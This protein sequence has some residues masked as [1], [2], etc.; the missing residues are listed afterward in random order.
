MNNLAKKCLLSILSFAAA[1]IVADVI[2]GIGL[3]VSSI[4]SE[5]KRFRS[6]V[7]PMETRTVVF[8]GNIDD[9]YEEPARPLDDTRFYR[10]QPRYFRTDPNGYIRGAAATNMGGGRIYRIT[11]CGDSVT[12]CFEV[13]EDVRF[14]SLVGKHMRESGLASVDTRSMGVRGYTSQDALNL[15]IN[16]PALRRNDMLVFMFNG[17]DIGYLI[18]KHS[19]LTEVPLD[20]RY[21]LSHLR[22]LSANCLDELVTAVCYNSNLAFLM[23]QSGDRI[24][25]MRRTYYTLQDE[26]SLL[27]Q[28]HE[29]LRLLIFTCRALNIQPVFM[30]QPSALPGGTARRFNEA[31]VEAGL[32]NGVWVVDAASAFPKES[33]Q[34]FFPDGIHL[35]NAGS[36]FASKVISD[37][38][39][40]L[41][42]AQGAEAVEQSPA[43]T[44]IAT[45]ELATQRGF[46]F[47]SSNICE[48][49]RSLCLRQQTVASG[50]VRYPTLSGDGRHILMQRRNGRGNEVV[51]G[52]TVSGRCVSVAGGESDV[53]PK[54]LGIDMRIVFTDGPQ[55]KR[56][57][58][59]GE[60]SP[61]CASTPLSLP[62][63]MSA[64]IPCP[65]SDGRTIYFAGWKVPQD[66]AGAGRVPDI[67]SV[68]GGN[69]RQITQTAYEEWRPVP[70]PDSR[71]LY[72]IANPAGHFDLFRKDMTL[73]TG[74]PEVVYASPWDKWDPSI[75]PDGS[76]V[77][78]ASKERG[79]WG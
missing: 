50:P 64:A 58:C 42:K 47:T 43:A 62:P 23:M 24:R 54:F 28:F 68:A 14:G 63:D 37:S 44:V 45:N 11:F 5:A 39:V 31:I 22:R 72:F 7:R 9:S 2:V 29:N 17:N 6:S 30:T 60:A 21:S 20:R 76:A 12:E 65:A 41:L 75:S 27:R 69:L 33:Q 74:E 4:R 8:C 10:G 3:D 40:P 66:G 36:R 46:I 71:W 79:S 77:A 18:E 56:R 59:T 16:H 49:G 78:F 13:D 34:L 55:N 73:P 51:V 67:Y 57:L 61:S 26:D 35:N 70:S 53:H 48:I 38:L 15:L 52:D 32:D 19:Y 1:W 25:E